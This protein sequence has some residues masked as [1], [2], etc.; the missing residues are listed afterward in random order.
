MQCGQVREL[1]ANKAPK[2]QISAAVEV[3]SMAQWRA[4][5]AATARVSFPCPMP[6]KTVQHPATFGTRTCSEEIPAHACRSSVRGASR[7]AF[8]AVLTRHA[9]CVPDAWTGASWPES[10][11]REGASGGGGGGAR[12]RRR[13]AADLGLWVACSC[14]RAREGAPGHAM[15]CRTPRASSHAAA[16]FV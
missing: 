5:S 8:L 4:S 11:G 2:D 14:S 12:D 16:R 3:H 6:L 10:G 13:A 15:P 9:R 7:S 1:K